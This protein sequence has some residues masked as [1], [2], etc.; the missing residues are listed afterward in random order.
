V[1]FLFDQ[2][3][4]VTEDG[5]ALTTDVVQKLNQLGWKHIV[6]L[7]L[8][9]TVIPATGV[10][11]PNGHRYQLNDSSEVTLQKTLAEIRLVHGRIGMFLHLHPVFTKKL[12]IATAFAETEKQ[13]LKLVYFLAKHLKQDLTQV[14]PGFRNCF[15]VL[16]RLNGRLGFGAPSA[17]STL[18]GGLFGLIKTVTIEWG[19]VYCRA[20]DVNPELDNTAITD[21]LPQELYD[22]DS[23][24][25]EVGYSASGR[26][27]L[28]TTIDT[29][30]ADQPTS[31]NLNSDSVFLVA[32]GAKG[33]TATC[34]KELA[35][36]FQPG[37]ILLG[38]SEFSSNEPEW[39]QG[40]ST[41]TDLKKRC[42][43]VLRAEGEKPTPVKIRT[44]LKPILAQRE[45]EQTLAALHASGSQAEYI[46]LDILDTATLKQKLQPV[47]ARLG[48]ITGII[49]GAGVLAD[50]LITEKTEKDYQTV[51]STKIDGL[52]SLLQCASPDM[53]RHLVLFSSAAGFYGNEAQSDYATAN[54]ILN[55]FAHLFKQI[56]P[57]CHVIAFNWG[58]WDGGM[59]TPPLKRLFEER[60]I[61]VIPP[62]VGSGIMADELSLPD[63][64]VA[65][66][67]IGSSMVLPRKGTTAPQS[68][69]LVRRLDLN[70]N[71]FLRDHMIGKEPVLPVV[72]ALAWMAD[73]CEQ[74]FPGYRLVAAE[75]TRVLKGIVFNS[76]LASNY[77]VQLTE[78]ESP[79]S[80][81]RAFK[82]SVVSDG[83]K[84]P[85]F[86]YSTRIKLSPTSIAGPCFPELNLIPD[87]TQDGRTFYTNGTLF[88]GP[89][90]QLV[91]NQVNLGQ[92]RL[93]LFCQAE[94]IGEAD[95]GQFRV[96]S[97][98][99]YA[100]DALLQ[101]LLIWVRHR[102]QAASLPLRIEQAE[103]YS[104]IPFNRPYYVSLLVKS[105]SATKLVADVTA[106]DENGKIY[107]RLTGAEAVI[108]KALDSK[109]KK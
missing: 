31:S 25:L 36:R 94:E 41:E 85:V 48:E 73:A 12:T 57:S 14:E 104:Q 15:M 13:V 17:T 106:H 74:L 108:S 63:K 35:I 69:Q 80:R 37:F 100:D 33:V 50:K 86:H 84:Q 89:L 39:S 18:A 16:T 72:C 105:S 81:E 6:I 102:Y 58:P 71:P 68:H 99:P 64:S 40:V 83:S 22:A 34:I 53:L 10:T 98:N 20:V 21:I 32:G 42:M 49:H 87:V 3:C 52:H 103:F 79:T 54:E 2:V 26:V 97:F 9:A 8:P 67:V 109:F 70:A 62:E 19:S 78:L 45:I 5:S 93:T 55:K 95:Q 88:H 61:K 77:T 11:I 107:S 27:T 51:V 44:R 56:H 30:Q 65:Q 7:G 1:R 66:V 75:D 29:I 46:S 4:L 101:A 76:S 92:D 59:V 47:V 82:V 90:L 23:R 24:L 60:N 28:N 91:K 38:R 96:G 43:E